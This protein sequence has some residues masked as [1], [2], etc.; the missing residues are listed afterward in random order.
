MSI[1]IERR[2]LLQTSAAGAVLLGTGLHGGPA[3]AE[4]QKGGRMRVAYGHGST[5]DS[6]DPGT[7]E[8]DFMIA[9]SH[10]IYN[11][12]T[13][14]DANGEL[15]GE[16]AESW[17]PSE[18][19]ATW[20]FKL[21]QGVQFHNGKTVEPADVIAS[22]D[23]HRGEDSKS[24]AKV[25][26]DAVTEMKADG[27]DT[28]V[29]TLSEGNADFAFLVSDYHL[30]IKPAKDGKIDPQETVGTGPYVLQDFDPGVRAFYTRN[31]DYWK[32]DRAWF[33][34]IEFLSI[35]DT[36]ARTNALLS[37]EVDLIS[38]PDLKTIHLMQ[39]RPG[40]K[41]ETTSGTQHYTMPMRCDTDPFTD[42]NVR[43]A[44]KYAIDRPTLVQTILQGFGQVGNDHPIGPSNPHYAAD[45]PQREYDPEQARSL[46]KK[47]GKE[48]IKVSIHVSDAA[49][50]GA[51]DACSLYSEA[52]R[53]AG[54]DLQVA[55]EPADG[56]W[57][58][59]WMQKPWSCSYW[60]GRPTEDWMFST[61]YVPGAEWNESFWSNDRFVELLREARVTLDEAKRAEMY[62]EMQSICRD[63]CGSVIPMFADYVFA[64]HE[65]VQHPEQLAANWDMDGHRYGERWWFA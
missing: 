5:T 64:M 9:L 52:A 20:T 17:E 59:V 53:A 23:H 50:A 11:F 19:A 34:E 61:A 37:D 65:R 26:L 32:A 31:P 38:R 8:N 36:A 15:I 28:V 47:A 43:L 24:A 22:L 35:L 1:L 62:Y 21:R 51:V 10:T 45:L 2:R 48:G 57:S 55:R 25:I 49:F 58:N 60:G 29:I 39:R 6:L 7:Y 18:D 16:L 44:M 46:L 30:P 54:I 3:R 56:Y 27:S 12:L 41:I 63:D 14:I 40:L 13:E 42:N 33:D 4:P